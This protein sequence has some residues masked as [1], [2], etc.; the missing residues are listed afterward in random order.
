MSEL[1]PQG[2][3]SAG[4]CAAR[5]A[6]RLAALLGAGRRCWALAR[7]RRPDV[8][9]GGPSTRCRAAGAARSAASPESAQRRDDTCTRLTW[10]RT[11]TVLRGQERHRRRRQQ[12]DRR[13]AERA[14][15]VF[16]FSTN[17]ATSITYT[18]TTTVTTRSRRRA[19]LTLSSTLVLTRR[20]QASVVAP[21]GNAG[22]QRQRR[23][24]RLCRL[25]S[26]TSLT[27]TA[28]IEASSPAVRAASAN[29][30]RVRSSTT[31][32]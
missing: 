23:D 3:G 24:H 21:A 26:G 29:P 6:R 13:D 22:R 30:A 20:R 14:A 12:D 10:A 15:T 27:F 11:R 5:T 1:G 4:L 19:T 25:S 32:G 7:A 17:G 9:T 16:G 28:V 18:S 31:H 8:I 2:N